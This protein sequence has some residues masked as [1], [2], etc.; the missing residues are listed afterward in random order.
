MHNILIIG[1]GKIGSL[2]ACLLA[3]AENY[4]ITLADKDFSGADAQR[5]L[6]TKH[7]RIHHVTLDIQDPNQAKQIIQ[8]QQT[9]AIISC[10]PYFMNAQV[11]TLA[12]AC[13][14]HYFDLTEDVTVTEVVKQHAA[15]STNAFVPQCGLA[16][17]LVGIVANSLMQKFAQV[18]SVKMRVGALPQNISN[19]LQYAL[20]WSTEGLINEY[21]NP[22]DAIDNGQRISLAPLE[23]LE[24]IELDG[25][26]YE[27]F[28]TSGG[29]GSLAE[30]YAGKVNSMNY[31]TIRY[32][33]H[34]KHMR[35]LMNELKLNQDRDTLKRILENAIPKTQQDV[36]IIYVSVSG[37]QDNQYIEEN[38]LNKLYPSE[39]ADM[40]WSAIQIA[41]ASGVSTVVDLVLTHPQAYQGLVHQEQFALQD[42][43]NNRFAKYL[44]E[45]TWT[46]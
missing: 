11:A 1:A 43:L 24:T 32:P 19:A 38:Y 34:C 18:D 42:V 21:G 36:V 16:P 45:K 20:T 15:Q 27:A 17:G 8:Q 33:G 10:L 35:F 13:G 29:L 30:L 40:S 6:Q 7:P 37:Q 9:H 14:T 26:V 41:T 28:N 23:G 25:E 2:I 5:L 12:Q 44:K 3:E 4:Q 22:C 31:K 46:G 39:I